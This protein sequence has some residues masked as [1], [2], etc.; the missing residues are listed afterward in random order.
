LNFQFI[1]SSKSLQLLTPSY[2]F[3]PGRI[4]GSITVKSIPIGMITAHDFMTHRLED[5]VKSQKTY[6]TYRFQLPGTFKM[7]P[8]EPIKLKVTIISAM[9]CPR[10]I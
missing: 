9:K 7:G 1:N 2:H 3:T 8:W 4:L 5:I 6:N 10:T